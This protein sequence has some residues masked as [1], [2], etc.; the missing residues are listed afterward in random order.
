[1][2]FADALFGRIEH[3]GVDASLSYQHIWGRALDL[4]GAGTVAGETIT[5]RRALCLSAVYGSIRILAEGVSK[6]PIRAAIGTGSM[7][8]PAPLPTWITDPSPTVTHLTMGEIL[9][10]VMVSMLLRGN[11]YVAT[12]RDQFGQIDS[13]QVLDPDVVEPYLPQNGPRVLRFRVNG[14]PGFTQNDISM[15]I[16]MSRP[17]A[18]TGMSPIDHA[19]ETIGLGLAATEFGAAFFG[20][21]ANPSGLIELEDPLSEEG[22]EML[23]QSWRKLHAGKRAGGVAVLT[24]GAKFKTL[25]ITPDNAQFLE[26]RGFQV[27]DIARFFGV[28]PHLLADASGSTSWG[29]GLAEQSTNYVTHALRPWVER[30]ES[31]L[32]RMARSE[33]PEMQLDLSL[34]MDHLLRGD[35]ATRMDT[36]GKAL[37]NGIYNLDEVRRFEGLPPIPDGVGQAHRVPLNTGDAAGDAPA[38][39]E[40]DTP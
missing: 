3:R 22:E 19:A 10:Q 40:G 23:R 16:G 30:I 14:K 9:D 26:T 2:R 12:N 20:N 18:I 37:M 28:P 24:E 11:A 38:T 33:R 31:L 1:M 5:D 7:A 32:T 21:G 27:A 15:V 17:G 25:S 6:L 13:L 29:S 4:R 35:F 36:Y 34:S 39:Y 8:E